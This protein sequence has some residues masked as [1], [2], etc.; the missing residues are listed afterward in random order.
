MKKFRFM[1]LLIVLCIPATATGG[2]WT[3]LQGAV[4]IGDV[5]QVKMLLAGGADVHDRRQGLQL[6]EL[7]EIQ[8]RVP[9]QAVA[10]QRFVG[11][12]QVRLKKSTILEMSET[13]LR[14]RPSE[15]G[16]LLLCRS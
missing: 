1:M 11:P 15:T 14:L 2:E 5:E 3:A 7:P 16:V 6:V 4:F 12:R 9:G 8:V 10:G 13:G